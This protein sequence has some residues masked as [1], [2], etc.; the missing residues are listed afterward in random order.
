MGQDTNVCGDRLV[1]DKERL[2]P[3]KNMVD[4]VG[5]RRS[6][7]DLFLSP[8]GPHAPL[9]QANRCEANRNKRIAM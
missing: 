7:I 1:R 8:P 5:R 9:L 2:A 3:T 4:Y 6:Q